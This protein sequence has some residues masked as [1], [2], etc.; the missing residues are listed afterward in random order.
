VDW[1]AAAS[2]GS[3][4]V[5]RGSS[6]GR[7]SA[8]GWG[9]NTPSNNKKGAEWGRKQSRTM[10]L[11]LSPRTAAS[12][13]ETG[14]PRLSA[15][16]R[17]CPRPDGRP[18]PVR[19]YPCR[20]GQ[21]SV[22]RWGFGACMELPGTS[23]LRCPVLPGKKRGTRAAVTGTARIG[24]GKAHT[25]KAQ[26]SGPGRMSV[27]APPGG[28]VQRRSIRRA[29]SGRGHDDRPDGTADRPRFIR[30]RAEEPRSDAPTNVGSYSIAE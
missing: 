29:P 8:L 30:W 14:P 22:G 5:T 3:D 12:E 18:A 7:R 21:Q 23:G 11:S 9:M 24:G 1:S 17:G 15:R 16:A 19:N 20:P 6:S 28:S 27:A 25:G 4:G 13:Q 2:A 26:A 10:S